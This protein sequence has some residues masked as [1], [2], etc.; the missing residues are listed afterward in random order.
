MTEGSWED[1]GMLNR[2]LD[3]RKQFLHTKCCDAAMFIAIPLLCKVT[4]I[5]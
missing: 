3:R 5:G 2:R 1:G 4:E